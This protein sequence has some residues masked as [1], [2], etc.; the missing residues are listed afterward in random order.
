MVFNDSAPDWSTWEMPWFLTQDD[1]DK[2][3]GQW[4]TAPGTHRQL[5]I[6]QSLFP[7]VLANS[8]WLDAGASGA[9]AAHARALARNL[10]A[11]GLGDSVIRLAA[12]ANL[13]TSP[14][15]VSTTGDDLQLW[16]TFWR[17][18]VIAMRSVPGARF[19]FDWCINARWRPIRLADFYPGDDVVDIIGIDAYDTGV[20]PGLDRWSAIYDRPDGIRAVLQFATK[21]GKPMSF[22]EWGL[23][24]SGEPVLGGGSDPSY[25]NHMAGF[26]AHHSVAYQSYFYKT[27]A[28]T[29]LSQSPDSMSAYRRDFGPLSNSAGTLSQDRRSRRLTRAQRRD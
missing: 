26:I 13:D 27:D 28:A 29:L 6:S 18:T 19:Q 22:P 10:V 9:Y 12:E 4:A 11:A 20:G 1:P 16:R 15:A 3:W 14:W 25:I 8:D 23:R 21:H 17:R 2:Q 24:T 5:I 7:G